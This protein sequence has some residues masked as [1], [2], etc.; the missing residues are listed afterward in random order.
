MSFLLF[1]ARR[2]NDYD[3][4]Q[5]GKVSFNEHLNL[6]ASRNIHP[7]CYE[8]YI[9]DSLR[10]TLVHARERGF[11]TYV[12]DRDNHTLVGAVNC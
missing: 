6:L 9:S 5:G 8:I 10:N 1:D 11:P 4:G 12:V 2:S 7:D 3:D